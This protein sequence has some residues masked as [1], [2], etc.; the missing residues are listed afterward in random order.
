[1]SYDIVSSVRNQINETTASFWSDAEIELYKQEAI[2]EI[3]L[4]TLDRSYSI[5]TPTVAGTQTYVGPGD[6]WIAYRRVLYDNTPLKCITIRDKDALHFNSAGGTDPSGTPEMYWFDD[7][8]I[9]LY[10]IP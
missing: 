9:Y 4:I 5:T 3:C 2:K 1:M 7:R 10:P 8:Y 6:D